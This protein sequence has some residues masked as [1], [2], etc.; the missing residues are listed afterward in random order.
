MLIAKTFAIGA[1]LTNCSDSPGQ[2]LAAMGGSERE[3]GWLKGLHLS[4]CGN[5]FVLCAVVACV[6][7]LPKRRLTSAAT[8][9]LATCRKLTKSTD[10]RN[11]LV[12][13]PLGGLGIYCVP[14]ETKRVSRERQRHANKPQAPQSVAVTV[15]QALNQCY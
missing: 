11:K 1:E 13:P 10:R 14:R 2:S 3:Y 5:N 15:C 7:A 4:V 9:A 6:C 8:A 12:L